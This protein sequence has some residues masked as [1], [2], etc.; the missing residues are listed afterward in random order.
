MGDPRYQG[1]IQDLEEGGPNDPRAFVRENLRC[2]VHFV[3]QLTG[4]T[5][6]HKLGCLFA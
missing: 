3:K 2:H 4:A 6:T 5:Y 1:Q